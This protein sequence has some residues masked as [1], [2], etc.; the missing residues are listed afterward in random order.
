MYNSLK[1][2]V[3]R[4]AKG[5][6]AVE[7]K[8][9][10]VQ[11]QRLAGMETARYVQSRMNKVKAFSSQEEIMRYAVESIEKIGGGVENP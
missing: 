1:K 3:K 9:I 4:F 5:L 6:L 7:E 11:L 10:S 8:S 2:R